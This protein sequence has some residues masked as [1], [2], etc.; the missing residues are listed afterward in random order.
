VAGSLALAS[1]ATTRRRRAGLLT[2]GALLVALGIA[3][4]LLDPSSRWDDPLTLGVL[5]VLGVIAI[6]SEVQLPSG[7]SFEALSAL[8]LIATA[9][10][11]AL[12]ALAVTL[13]PVAWNALTGRERLLRAGNLANL[14]AYGGYALVGTALLDATVADPTAP[15]AFGWL[16]IVGLV[17]LVLNWALGPAVYVTFWLGHPTRT[18]LDML[19][20]GI[21]TGALMVLLGA[22]TVVLTPAL[23]LL[24]LAVFAAI[25]VLPQSM[26]TFA[27]RTRPVARLDRETATRRY[28]QALALHLHLSR[29]ERRHLAGVADAARQ[30]P[31]TGGTMDY[32][33]ATLRDRRATVSH[34]QLVSEW[35]DGR[36]GPIGLRGE[37]IPI[38]ARVLAVAGTWSALTASGTPQLSHR[39]A[40]SDLEI[41][42]G[43]RLD[44]TIVRAARDVIAEERVTAAE[45]A[46]EPRLHR[47]R[48]PSAMRRMLAAY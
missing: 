2:H 20:D 36:G 11:G 37:A 39:A 45:P 1:A 4:A 32:I 48:L 41:A 8:A 9:L 22:C 3:Y 35:W 12:P 18:V 6:R 31:S 14:V 33:H 42:A 26:L 30:W 40:L 46:P 13:T 7:V 44:P 29:A 10:A 25:V 5:V 19:R 21:P 27:A 28:A 15:E 16:L 17:Q 24:A 38:A 23:G 43:T 34:A 47:L